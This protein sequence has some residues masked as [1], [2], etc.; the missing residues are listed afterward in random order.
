MSVMTKPFYGRMAALIFGLPL[1]LLTTAASAFEAQPLSDSQKAEL[2][3]A[4]QTSLQKK[5]GPFGANT[6]VCTDGRSAPLLTPSGALHNI[7]GDQT[8]FCAAFKAEWGK[9]LEK[10]RVYVAN[11]FS[12][13][14]WEWDRIADHDDLVRGYILERY[15]I[16]TVPENKLSQMRQYGGLSGA[17]YEVVAK[18][19]F[20]ERYLARSAY[21]DFRHYLL[22]YELQKRH[23]ARG[24]VGRMQEVRNMASRIQGVDPTFK[25][26]RD[27]THNQ[28]SASLIPLL[29][30]YRDNRASERTAQMTD[31][32]IAEIRALT[33]LDVEVL[34]DDIASI[35]DPEFSGK[36][37][38]MARDATQAQGVDR[39]DILADMMV[40]VRMA[41]ADGSI[42]AADRRRAIDL[43]VVASTVLQSEGSRLID[44][45]GLSLADTVRMMRALAN[46][47]YGVGL[48]STRERQAAAE[49]LSA[50]LSQATIARTELEQRMLL[51]ERVVEWAQNSAVLAFSEVWSQWVYL[52]P[53]AVRLPDDI[54]RGS[55]LLLYADLHQKASDFATGRGAVRHDLG[56]QEFTGG[57]R[58]LNPGLAV[59]PLRVNPESGT[60]A[61]SE[62]VALE[63]TPEDLQPTAG[64]VTQGEGNVVSHVQLL[65]RALGIPN[66]V[67]ATEPFD[68]VE[69]Q[70]GSDVFYAVTPGGRVIMKNAAQ[71]SDL[72]RQVQAEYTGN[73]A[74]DADGNLAGGGAGKLHIDK[75][76]LD[77]TATS[78]VDLATFRRADS[79]IR[80]GPKAAFLGELKHMFPDNV[81]RGVVLPFGVYHEHYKRAVVTVPQ[82]LAGAGIA[83]AGEPLPDF[84]RAT[85]AT[86]F[87]EMIPGGASEVELSDWIKSRLEVIGESITATPLDPTLKEEIRAELERIGLMDPNDPSRTIGMFVRSDTNVEDLENFNGAGLNLTIFN[88]ITLDEIYAGI[89]EVWASPFRYRS[90]SWR[91]T[92]I[93]DPEW[94]LPSIIILE[95]IPS[96]K[97]GV[98]VTAD[99]NTGNPDA[100]LMATSEGVGGAVDGTPA[101]TL[102]WSPGGVELVTMFKSPTRRMLQ[103][104]GGTQV[105]PSTGSEYVLNDE[106]I[107]AL[108]A[109]ATKIE[110]TLEPTFN[111][112][113]QARPWDIE[114]GFAGGKLWLFQSRPFI[115]SEDVANLPALAQLD[116]ARPQLSENVSLE[117]IV[118]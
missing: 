62:L 40:A 31:E 50:V 6:C 91:Q 100:I 76:Q 29:A 84:V 108:A 88:L 85:Y 56:G 8:L 22:A 16:D 60:Y 42:P 112:S 19:Q 74:R 38:M 117:D 3:A 116:E 114:Y 49:N 15:I 95:A 30:E 36:L 66:A 9:D 102:L 25:P 11:I 69:A 34:A 111:A 81:A 26:L 86:F 27:A 45:G 89:K 90:F 1:L 70:G 115:G 101:E 52:M 65:A 99:I 21:N 32:L 103:A 109:A 104:G 92:L 46:G 98:A 96:E 113:G 37:E 24:G 47:A 59:G 87:G 78:P 105:I 54:L 7:C 73:L 97:S 55:P 44:A 51:A 20:Y 4:W 12:R 10:N 5:K 107:A 110:T 64:I 77:L 72:E 28:I 33:S 41:V 94:V 106:E 83:T 57:V 35:E 61:R 39:I 53:E 67:M 82:E 80:G 17:E 2:S 18:R 71:M 75:E 118:E 63:A 14:L 93:D 68:A 79:G 58:A 43:N 23:F 48:L 13:D